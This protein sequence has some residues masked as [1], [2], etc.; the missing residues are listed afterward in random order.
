[1]IENRNINEDEID[2]R[3][4]FHVIWKKKLFILSFTFIITLISGIYIY[5]KTPIY[6]VKSFVEIGY[7]NENM[8]ED[9]NALEQKLKVVFSIGESK[10]ENSYEKGIVTSIK[11][12]KGVKNFLEIKTEAYSNEIALNKNKEI[13][14]FIQDLSI[15]KIKQYEIIL[16]N[17]ILD[18]KR[19]IDFINNLEIK[20]IKSQIEILK[21]QEL[22]NID[23]QIE[24]FRTQN[25]EVINKKI[26]ILKTQEIPTL[27]KHI[28]FL[29][30]SK[31]KTLQDKKEYY[32]DS[33]KTYISQLDKLN[34]NVDNQDDSTSSLTAAIQMINYQNLITDAQNKIKDLDIQ[35]EI[36]KNETIPKVKHELEN[37]RTIEIK[38]L[39]NDKKN[40][41]NVNIK[42]L[43][44]KKLNVSNETIR[45]LED[46]INIELRTKITQLNEKI[47]TLNFKKSE[48]NLSNS[49]LVG[50]YIINDKPIK[51]K[52][53][54]VIIV[55]FVSSF[56]FGIFIVFIFNFFSNS[57]RMVPKTE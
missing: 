23:R 56:I 43:E 12:I 34:K 10:I 40:I 32:L 15:E 50:D 14:K 11:Q 28:E 47:D 4:L 29:S 9:I 45:K 57:T 27:K 31:I 8:I 35:I 53:S 49:K 22:K 13:L 37:I 5:N 41:F 18:T 38:K 6:E 48:Q 36:I 19:E 55:S 20:N 7:I 21:E 52:K 1:M 46:K 33:L 54:L 2:L 51:P 30:K 42:D 25:I 3:E 39:E 44:N 16:D 24:I 17:D 26:D